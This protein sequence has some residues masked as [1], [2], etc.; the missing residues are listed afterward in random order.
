MCKKINIKKLAA[1][2]YI[3]ISLAA[4]LTLYFIVDSLLVVAFSFA[5][6]GVAVIVLDITINKPKPPY[7]YETGAGQRM[8]DHNRKLLL[9]S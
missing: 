4:F 1:W 6:L 3:A 8:I 2:L 5:N 9:N 7:R